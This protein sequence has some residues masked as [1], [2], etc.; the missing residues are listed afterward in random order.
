MYEFVRELKN[1]FRKGDM[2]LLTLCLVTSAFST[3]IMA[4]VT[5]AAKFGG[6]TRYIIIHIVAVL[7]GVGLYAIV[8]CI[9][10]EFFQEHRSW[11]IAANIL[12]LAMLIPFGTD[13]GTGNRS[14]LD[15]PFLPINIQPAEICKIFYI[16]IMASVMSSHQNRL[17]SIPSVAHMVI[18]LGL[19]VGL[20]MLISRDAGV[21]LIFAAIFLGMVFAGGVKWYWFAL[22]GGALAVAGPLFWTHIMTT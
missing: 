20:N 2:V 14:W 12:L 13:N 16:L 17:S 22:G 19:I 11:F 21:S 10:A 6:S 7:L 9:D 5:N 3:L 1:F 4:S 15:F 8:S 18:H